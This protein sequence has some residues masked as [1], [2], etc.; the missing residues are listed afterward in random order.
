MASGTLS[1]GSHRAHAATTI[2]M[3]ITRPHGRSRG[4]LRHS[5]KSILDCPFANWHGR[6][7]SAG[8]PEGRS[9]FRAR[10]LNGTEYRRGGMRVAPT[11]K[12]RGG[13]A[14]LFLGV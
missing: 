7:I 3:M 10:A 2:T 6:D 12:T 5:R 8:M 9:P 13:T 4:C 11:E 14:G 1:P